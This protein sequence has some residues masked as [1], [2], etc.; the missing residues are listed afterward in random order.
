MLTFLSGLF[1]CRDEGE[2][3]H[4]RIQNNSPKD[5]ANFWLGSGAGGGGKRSRSYGAIAIGKVTLYKSLEPIYGSY[6]NYNFTTADNKQY[7]GSA[8]P[9]EDIGRVGLEPGYYTFAFTIVSDTAV[10]QIISEPS[11]TRQ[12]LAQLH[13]FI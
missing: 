6:G 2:R 3:V 8:F 9:K 7:W 13:D 5:I 11:P 1:S 4:V 10:L 12:Q